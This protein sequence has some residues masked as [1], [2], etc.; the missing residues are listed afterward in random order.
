MSN[1]ITKKQ[2]ETSA[3]Y[4]NRITGNPETAYTRDDSG[5]FTAN[6]GN[7]HISYAY[8]GACLHQMMNE[9][10]GV[11]CPIEHCHVPKRELWDKMQAFIAGIE[12]A[13]RGEA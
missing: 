8:G 12:L 9:G 10:G 2:L 11:T 1:R 4:L 5:K 7:Y 3:D 13:K 6:I